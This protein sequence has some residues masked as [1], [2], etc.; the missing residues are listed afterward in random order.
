MPYDSGLLRD[1]EPPKRVGDATLR[2][3]VQSETDNLR[4][5]TSTDAMSKLLHG[6]RYAL[7]K[8]LRLDR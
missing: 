2:D 3:T 8:A 6:D 7:D 1:W 5:A 4:A